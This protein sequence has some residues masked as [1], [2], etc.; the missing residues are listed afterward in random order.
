M[1][2]YSEHV[3][4]QAQRG[5]GYSKGMMMDERAMLRPG[6]FHAMM[7]GNYMLGQEAMYRE[8][9]MPAANPCECS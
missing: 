2:V 3:T 1:Q 8:E 6:H 9:P 5:G 4:G 7:T